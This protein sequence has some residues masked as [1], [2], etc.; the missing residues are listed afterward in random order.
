[1]NRSP[2]SAPSRNSSSHAAPSMGS[3][4]STSPEMARTTWG[5]SIVPKSSTS[6]L[7]RLSA[8]GELDP[9]ETTFN[10]CSPSPR[11]TSFTV[12]CAPSR[13][14]RTGWTPSASIA[15]E[16]SSSVTVTTPL[17][18]GTLAARGSPN[19][20]AV[21]VYGRRLRPS[22][23]SVDLLGPRS[24]ARGHVQRWSPKPGM[25]PPGSPRREASTPSKRY[26]IRSPIMPVISFTVLRMSARPCIVTSRGPKP[27]SYGR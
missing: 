22:P 1:V 21:Q 3:P 7:A 9:T 13:R 27:T 18:Q 19:T 17:G 8:S 6:R 14:L 2:R 10:T 16:I 26:L 4:S 25:A 15:C 20:A 5:W 12:F 23:G 24:D 11:R